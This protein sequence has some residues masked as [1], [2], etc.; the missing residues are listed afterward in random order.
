MNIG[1]KG[2]YIREDVLYLQFEIENSS[3]INFDVDQ[4]RFMVRDKK[5]SKRTSS[6]ELELQP[7]HIYGN[8][9]QVPSLSEHSLTV[10]IPK[11]TMA[12]KKYLSV[13][14]MEKNGGRHLDLKISN[15]I[16][17]RAERVR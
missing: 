2:I 12:D 9:I 16:L 3:N 14:L 15:K 4:L 5:K 1:L 6:Q 11:L 10:A 17:M 7:V 13:Q 8:I